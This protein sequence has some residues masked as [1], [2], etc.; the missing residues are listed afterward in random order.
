MS[1]GG[2]RPESDSPAAA[3]PGSYELLMGDMGAG[4]RTP[5]D[6]HALLT[7]EPSFQFMKLK[8][9]TKHAPNWEYPKRL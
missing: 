5:Q 6:Q 7:L 9:S 1:E 3:A 4:S 2:Q 8:F